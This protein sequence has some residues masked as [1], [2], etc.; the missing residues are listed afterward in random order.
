MPNKAGRDELEDSEQHRVVPLR[1]R[2]A[3]PH[4]TWQAGPQDHPSPDSDR[5]DRDD[6]DDY[7]GRMLANVIGL[8]LIVGLIAAG[9]WLADAIADMRK[10]Q[11]CVLTGRRNCVPIEMPDNA[12]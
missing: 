7:R 1:R 10:Q 11:D 8:V 9:I 12:R 2:G 5:E 3:A 6:T 4:S